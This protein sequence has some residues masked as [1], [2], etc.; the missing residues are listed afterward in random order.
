[1]SYFLLAFLIDISL[2]LM[3]SKAAAI[4]SS[5]TSFLALR[6]G[7]IFND[8]AGT[9]GEEVEFKDEVW[10]DEPVL[11]ETAGGGDEAGMAMVMSS[12]DSSTM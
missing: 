8:G 6:L 4:V 11:V 9:V 3:S 12:D 2:F 1:M 5:L 10:A 7:L